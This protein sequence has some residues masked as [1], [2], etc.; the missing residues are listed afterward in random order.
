MFRTSPVV[1]MV[2]GRFPADVFFSCWCKNIYLPDVLNIWHAIEGGH[3]EATDIRLK[4]VTKRQE[5]CSEL[6]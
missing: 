6:E 3:Q 2:D 5:H 1:F 4:V